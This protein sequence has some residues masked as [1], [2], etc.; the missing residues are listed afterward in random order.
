MRRGAVED[1]LGAQRSPTPR[2]TPWRCTA[3]TSDNPE[4]WS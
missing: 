2:L 3:L 4:D 1:H